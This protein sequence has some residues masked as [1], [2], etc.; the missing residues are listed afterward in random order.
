MKS[1]CGAP[2]SVAAERRGSTLPA[3]RAAKTSDAGAAPEAASRTSFVPAR[4]QQGV[5]I[6]NRWQE[7]LYLGV[8]RLG[9]FAR[10]PR[11]GAQR[12]GRTGADAD[13][14]RSDRSGAYERGGRQARSPAASA[15]L[16][17][18][19]FALADGGMRSVTHHRPRWGRATTR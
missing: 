16:R 11:R 17:A 18:S 5:R 10:T 7:H 4:S 19:T 12:Y 14:V 2:V 1:F 6:R 3:A 8:Y 13:G 9:D 15:A